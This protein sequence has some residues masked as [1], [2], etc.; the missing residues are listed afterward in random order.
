MHNIYSSLQAEP[1]I[2][3]TEQ[4]IPTNFRDLLEKMV[5]KYIYRY[6]SYKSWYPTR[7]YCFR[8]FAKLDRKFKHCS[9]SVQVHLSIKFTF[10]HFNLYYFSFLFSQM[11]T[12]SHFF[13]SLDE[14]M[15]EKLCTCLENSQYLSNAVLFFIKLQ[16]VVL[17]LYQ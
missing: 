16:M 14:D 1:K 12:T 5:L 7:L 10:I 8:T 9:F 13:Q 3:V 15:K 17:I 11:N 2:N 4:S 6:L